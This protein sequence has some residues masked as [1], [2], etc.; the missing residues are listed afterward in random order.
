[1]KTALSAISVFVVAA[2]MLLLPRPSAARY[3]YA[4]GLGT[5]CSS[6]HDGHHPGIESLNGA[7]RYYLVNRT[8]DGF[9]PGVRARA[10]SAAPAAVFERNCAPC[11]GANGEGTPKA[12][13]LSPAQK[14][15]SAAQIEAVVRDGIAGTG[16]FGFRDV[17]AAEDIRA[18]AS[19]VKT[20]STR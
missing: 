12:H 7:G 4:R 1:M 2:L 9:A 18:V 3:E 17:L 11:H 5:R 15:S 8:L 16:M 14:A 13:P 20:L 10:K 6:C 19:Y